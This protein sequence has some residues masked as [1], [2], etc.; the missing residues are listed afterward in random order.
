[1]L[2]LSP[3]DRHEG[4]IA[5]QFS[6]GKDSLAVAYLLRD[7]LHRMTVYHV[8]NGDQMAEVVEVVEHVRR[9]CP[10]FVT[11]RTDKEGWVRANGLPSDLVPHSSHWIGQ[12]MAESPVRLVSRYDC[13]FANIMQPMHERL[14]A[15]GHTLLIRGTKS[16]DMKR[17]PFAS[18][19]VR[20]GVELMLPLEGWDDARVFAY[21]REVG[22]P[23]AP[24]YEAAGVVHTPEC[25]RC[26]AWLNESLALYLR[27]TY[28]EA[29]QDYAVRL[30]AIAQAVAPS[31]QHLWREMGAVTDAVQLMGMPE[32]AASRPRPDDSGT[33]R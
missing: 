5:F 27:R 8:A 33:E 17:L 2:D 21:L 24:V 10:H 7:H 18:G 28:P 1:M 4:R 19:E 22:A 25:V 20:D 29:F 3:L 13:C 32:P 16:S 26:S 6:G 11:I 15:D 30:G 31:V 9:M 14:K 23:I 12:Q